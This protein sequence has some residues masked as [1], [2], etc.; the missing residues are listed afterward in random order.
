MTVTVI[1]QKD[2]RRVHLAV[3]AHIVL[4]TMLIAILALPNRQFLLGYV[5]VW[6]CGVGV[7]AAAVWY[8]LWR[9]RRAR[10]QS[11]AVRQ[12][13]I[14]PLWVTVATIACFYELITQ[15]SRH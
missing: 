2:A 10:S 6:V 11:A 15:V 14:A 3:L 4:A 7:P 8:G 1:D 13:L 12:M 9:V 5:Q